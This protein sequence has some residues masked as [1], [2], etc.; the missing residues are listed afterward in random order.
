MAVQVTVEARDTKRFEE[1][2][3]LMSEAQAT[4]AHGPVA[5][6]ELRIVL[7]KDAAE[8]WDH[9]SKRHGMK[10][11]FQSIDLRTGSGNLSHRQPL[12]RS[13]GPHCETILDVTGG[14]GHDA[15]LLACM[16]WRVTCVERV[17]AMAAILGLSIREAMRSD[18]H[19]EALHN[20]ITVLHNEAKDVIQTGSPPMDVI[21]MDP[22]FEPR[23]G[24]ALPRKPAQLLHRLVEADM[25]AGDL[26]EVARGA[27]HRVVV[28]RP[29]DGPTLAPNPDLIFTT[30]QV[31]YDVYLQTMGGS[32]Q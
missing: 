17:P 12:A 19:A 23:Q 22:M 24:S 1:A 9:H 29:N 2:Q 31:R 16:G 21:Y 11:G 10:L 15:A 20:Q 3:Q 27:C 25:D 30:R 13:L 5:K 8:L 18:A 14:F 26:L 32:V 28:K 6:N 7:L 4:L